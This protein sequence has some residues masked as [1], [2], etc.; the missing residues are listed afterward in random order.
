MA[1]WIKTRLKG[2]EADKLKNDKGKW[3]NKLARAMSTI[4]SHATLEDDEKSAK[5]ETLVQAS[6]L[7]LVHIYFKDLGIV[8]YSREENFG[9]MDLIGKKKVTLF[10]Q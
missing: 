3:V 5:I 1:H 8:K 9:L 10:V 4:E 6:N 2:T 7:S